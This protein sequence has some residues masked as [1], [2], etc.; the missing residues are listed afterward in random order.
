MTSKLDQLNITGKVYILLY[1]PI[2]VHLV[3]VGVEAVSI[4]SDRVSK[5]NIQTRLRVDKEAWPPEPPKA[6]TP[7]LL[8]QHQSHRNLKQSTAMTKFVERGHIDK[9]ISLASG[10]TALKPSQ[11]PRLHP[12]QEVLDTSKIT[13]EVEKILAPLETSDDPQFILIEGAPG[14]GKSLLLKEIAYRWGK[15]EILQKFKLVLLVCLRNPA[16]QQM[17]L[18]DDLLQSFC[19]GDGRASEIA[20]D[21]SKYLFKNNG[22]DLVF[23]FDGYDE[24]PEMLREDSLIAYILQREVLPCCGLIV[25]SRPHASVS[26][27]E[28]ATVR[29]DILGFTEAERQHYI[30][31]SMKGQQQKN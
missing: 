9:V 23:L 29:V 11:H 21:C 24:Y 3:I 13:K 5:V 17:S 27:H 20:S 1:A 28:Q 26:L 31:E 6:F 4:L 7:L 10:D 18:I 12:L 2:I 25:S 14:I 19:K 8:I 22:E 16:V 30:K 15:K